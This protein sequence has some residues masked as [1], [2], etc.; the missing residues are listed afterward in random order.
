MTSAGIDLTLW[1]SSGG[2]ELL[3]VCKRKLETGIDFCTKTLCGEAEFNLLQIEGFG[4][5]RW[6]DGFEYWVG[7]AEMHLAADLAERGSEHFKIVSLSSRLY[8]TR[9][10]LR[11]IERRRRLEVC[12][13]CPWPRSRRRMP[14]TATAMRWRKPNDGP[15][16]RER[17]DPVRRSAPFAADY[18]MPCIQA[19]DQSGLSNKARQFAE[20]RLKLVNATPSLEQFRDSIRGMADRKPNL[21]S[22]E[23]E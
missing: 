11:H 19:M 23:I 9:D 1:Q 16:R 7:R 18:W 21:R 4:F 13:N 20:D 10:R 15:R 2:D 5:P 6:A 3:E 17:T 12:R 8:P 22:E 14:S